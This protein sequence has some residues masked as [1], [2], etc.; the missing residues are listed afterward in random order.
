MNLTLIKNFFLNNN[1]SNN[2]KK[3][4]EP[5]SR[6]LRRSFR[7]KRKIA[8]SR[9][10]RK[11]GKNYEQKNLYL[12]FWIVRKFQIKFVMNDDDVEMRDEMCWFWLPPNDSQIIA[13]TLKSRHFLL[14][15]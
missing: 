4:I 7:L 15:F 10:K 13:K 3:S 6:V 9:D 12:I 1:N 5:V 14:M 2:D 11:S 8:D